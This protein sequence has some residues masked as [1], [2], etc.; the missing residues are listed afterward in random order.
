MTK[1][2]REQEGFTNSSKSKASLLFQ[3]SPHA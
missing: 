1:F 3:L 2:I